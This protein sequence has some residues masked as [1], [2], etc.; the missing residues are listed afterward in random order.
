MT[1]KGQKGTLVAPISLRLCRIRARDHPDLSS[2]FRC[3]TRMRRRR[4]QLGKTKP[5]KSTRRPLFRILFGSDN[6]PAGVVRC[7]KFGERS[8]K[9]DAAVARHGKHTVENGVEKAGVTGADPCQH[10]APDIL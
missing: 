10:L 6:Q 7:R 5:S 1:A 9:I 8:R 3:E 4:P 2:L